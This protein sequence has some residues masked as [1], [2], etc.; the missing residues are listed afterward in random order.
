MVKLL[1]DI[2]L[3]SRKKDWQSMYP[4]MYEKLSWFK[5]S[6]KKINQYE[7]QKY[8][9]HFWSIK[10][11][12]RKTTLIVLGHGSSGNTV[13]VGIDTTSGE[14]VTI[15]EWV[16]K[17]RHYGRKKILRKEDGDEDKEGA[18][19]LKQVRLCGQNLYKVKQ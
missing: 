12:F 15:S 5:V 8:M 6:L 11:L 13:Y 16:L 14:L 10:C 3:I 2:F 7:V 9:M 19:C 4:I 1:F 17:W 18:A